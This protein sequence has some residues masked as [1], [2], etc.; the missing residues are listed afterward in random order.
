MSLPIKIFEP[1]STMERL[2]DAFHLFPYYIKKAYQNKDTV[3]RI[4]LI[5][6]SI[7]GSIPH[8]LS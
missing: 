5:L 3:E 4:K 6:A 7:V 8:T 1:R 2:L